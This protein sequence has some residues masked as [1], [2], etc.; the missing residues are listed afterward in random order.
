MVGSSRASVGPRRCANVVL[1]AAFLLSTAGAALFTGGGIAYASSATTTTGLN[2]RKLPS[3]GSAVRRVMPAGSS[4]D[5]IRKSKNGFYYID[6]QGSR[7]YAHGDYLDFGG[8]SSSGG[9]GGG[10][11]STGGATGKAKTTSSVNLRSGPST[12]NSVILL[13]PS[14]ATVTLNGKSSNGFL[15]VSY[16]GTSGWAYADYIGSAGSADDGG[17]SQDPGSGNAGSAT[18]TS[19]LNLRSGPSTSNKVILVMPGGA[20]VTLTGNSSGGFL[21]VIYKGTGGWASADYLDTSGGS[22]DGG[23]SDGG[24]SGGSDY[25]LDGNGSWSR[26]EIV[27]IIYAAADY[28]GQSRSSMLRVAQCESG[29]D[30]SN[31]TPPY[32]ASGLFQFLPGTWATTPYAGSDIYDPVASAFAAGWMWSVGR[33]GE[34]V[35]Q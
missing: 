28:Y 21:G 15:G 8:G 25:D 17:G 23:S 26:D 35:C 31:Y 11:V 6:Y 7:G 14:G 20:S 1:I 16:K 5:V 22:S 29:L 13:M 18:V 32:G 12:S 33:R 9:G 2:L 3:T 4:V 10:G 30:P 19:S 34:W 27:A 24:S